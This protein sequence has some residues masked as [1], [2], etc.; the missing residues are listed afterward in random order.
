[1]RQF[2][3]SKHKNN[4]RSFTL[5]ELLVVVAIIGILSILTLISI[6]H[7]RAKNRD[8]Q[9]VADI[10]TIQEALAMYENSYARYPVYEGYIVGNDKMSVALKND[11]LLPSVPVDP[12]NKSEEGF[13]YRYYYKS[14]AG[15]NYLIQFYLETD[16]VHSRSQ[17]LNT[18]VP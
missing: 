4:E 7:I 15:K 16:S 1:M 17:G 14:D 2:S 12:I 5:I 9:R 6:S 10:K 13:N 8:V 18:V 3:I 11:G